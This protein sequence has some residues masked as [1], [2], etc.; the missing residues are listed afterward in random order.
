MHMLSLAVVIVQVTVIRP[1]KG[2]I[3]CVRLLVLAT[4]LMV[5]NMGFNGVVLYTTF[6][7]RELFISELD[8]QETLFYDVMLGK[9]IACPER[10]C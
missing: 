5:I 8:K 10:K 3:I 7:L 2:T 9:M 1:G 6:F 4:P